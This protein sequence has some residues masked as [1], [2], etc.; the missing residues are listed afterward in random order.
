MDNVAVVQPVVSP[1]K[2]GKFDKTISS[3]IYT[4]SQVAVQFGCS[5]KAVRSR[6]KCGELIPLKGFVRPMRFSRSYIQK[7]LAK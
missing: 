3:Q 4:T 1:V 7:L 6:V 2:P 5:A